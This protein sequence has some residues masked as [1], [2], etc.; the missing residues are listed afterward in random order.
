MPV[1]AAFPPP[2][3]PTVKPPCSHETHRSP[4]LAKVTCR[5]KEDGEVTEGNEDADED[6]MEMEGAN[7][8]GP[9]HQLDL[10]ENEGSFSILYDTLQAVLSLHLVCRAFLYDMEASLEYQRAN[11]ASE[12]VLVSSIVQ[13]PP[14]PNLSHLHACVAETNPRT[15]NGSQPKNADVPFFRSIAACNI[16]KRRSTSLLPP[17]RS[18]S[19]DDTC[20]P[21]RTNPYGSPSVAPRESWSWDDQS[22]PPCEATRKP[23][24]SPCCCA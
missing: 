9:I 6:G 15:R 18:P 17:L 4:T 20:V 10:H 12:R 2:P 13:M 3:C 19:R 8:R 22:R 14:G 23:Q 24:R 16:L 7:V 1:L 5:R 21:R 11:K